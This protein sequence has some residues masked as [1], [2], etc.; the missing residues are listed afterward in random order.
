MH[1]LWNNWSTGTA[2]SS[3]VGAS[4]WARSGTS[5]PYAAGEDN[6]PEMDEL[7]RLIDIQ[8]KYSRWLFQIMVCRNEKTQLESNPRRTSN[9]IYKNMNR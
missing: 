3:T 8:S 9:K 5:E 6:P 2:G 4:E 7:P 1:K